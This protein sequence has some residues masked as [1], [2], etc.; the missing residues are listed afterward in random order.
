MHVDKHIQSVK[1]VT[2][3]RVDTDETHKTDRVLDSSARDNDIEN[4]IERARQVPAPSN[5][6]SLGVVG[7][8]QNTAEE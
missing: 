1:P 7:K 5:V 2:C 3:V 4:Q 6:I 8:L